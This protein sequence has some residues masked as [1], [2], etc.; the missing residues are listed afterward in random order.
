MPQRYYPQFAAAFQQ[1]MAELTGQRVLIQGH[2]RPDGDC[3]GAQ[4]ALCRC[5]NQNWTEAIAINQ[6]TVPRNL[7]SFVG[8]TP[9]YQAGAYPDTGWEAPRVINVD[10]ADRKRVGATSSQRHLKLHANIDH[11]LSNP[12]YATYNIVDAESAAC[13]EILAGLFLDHALPIDAIT[14][15][16]LYV[17]I[18]TDT[19]QFRF[20]S[21]TRQVFEICSRLLQLGAEPAVA[22][23]EL[24][25]R[26]SRAKTVL[27]QR[28]LASLEFAC[29][30]R[31]CIGFLPEGIYTETGTDREDA[32]GLVDYTRA[33]DGV[34]IGVSLEAYGGKIKGSL[35]AKDSVHRVD[36]LASQ[37]DGGGH[38][39]AAGFNVDGTLA[40]FYR[41]LLD[42]LERHF[43]TDVPR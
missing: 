27:L 37:F 15:Q 7:A 43:Q 21:T 38:A 20:A 3:I 25:E 5:L 35:R 28:F 16:A 1:A 39:N 22:A 41:E 8:D 19:G 9:F 6:D 33:I 17:G 31:V 42:V 12:N 29:E 14:A 30:G 4:V 2:L 24:Y 36:R 32:E 23:I 18:A 13:C 10:C 34:A 26:E 40:S 11:H